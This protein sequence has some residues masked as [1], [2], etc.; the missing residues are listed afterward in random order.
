MTP[1]TSPR[2]VPAYEALAADIKAQGIDT[3]FGLMSDDTALFVTTLDG[4]G[5]RFY[6][7]RHENNAV[8]MAEGFAAATGQLGIA[9]IGRG[10]ATANA[11]HASV[12]ASRTG[13]RVLLIYGYIATPQAPGNGMGPD[14]K[15]LN[16]PAVLEAAGITTFVATSPATAQRTLADALR[17][18]APGR[19]A[20]LLLPTSVQFGAITPEPSTVVPMASPKPAGARAAAVAAAA[21]L[22]N[23]ARKPLFIA[24]LGAHRAGAKQAIEQLA[25]RTGAVLA[26]SLKG[27]DL[28]HGHPFNLGLIGSYSHGAGRRLMD[29]ADCVVVFGAGLNQRT[30]SYGTS[31]PAG[32]PL[33]HIDTSRSAIGRWHH[34]DV[35]LVADAK[36]AAEQLLQATIVKSAADKPLHSDDNRR[37]LAAFNLASE[38]EAAHTPRT[39]DP[40]LAALAFDK[41]LPAG[42]NAVYDSGNFL[43][44][45]PYISGH[46]PHN[47]K[48]SHDFSSIGLGFGT[49][50]GYCLGSPGQTT[51]L[52]VGDGGFLMNLGELETVVRE[53]IPLVIVVMNDCAYGA[54]LHYLKMRDAPVGK[55]VC[56]DVVCAPIA[57]AL[58]VQSATVRTMDELQ[59]LAPLLA[60]PDGPIL[61]DCKI[62]ASVMAPFLLETVEHERRKA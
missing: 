52:F 36:S 55:S 33:I 34:A 12:Y 57:A 54:E 7:A 22:L 17:W 60:K 29:E 11:L 32:V 49:A 46:S 42:R 27:K 25:E 61:I 37:R 10:P 59:A 44:I 4:M 21:T 56:L 6:G 39:L 53:D 8:A 51:A 58:G 50:M 5:V 19:C 18:V 14:G 47:F 26:A 35:A 13:S 43:Q 24:G 16:A 30:T 40:R 23:N 9:I 15:A 48:G 3:V 45:V 62:N 41:L 2:A 38:V 28:F 20:A 31:I 1:I